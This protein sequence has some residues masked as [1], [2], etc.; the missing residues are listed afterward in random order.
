MGL[1][2][3]Q[4]RIMPEGIDTELDVLQKNA[5]A[6]IKELGHILHKVE[7]KDVAFGLKSLEVFIG[8]DE[9]RDQSEVEDSLAKIEHVSSVEVLDYRRAF[10]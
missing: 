3:L 4:I 5:E 10:G 8:V 9:S 7:V 6:K 1:A 2:I